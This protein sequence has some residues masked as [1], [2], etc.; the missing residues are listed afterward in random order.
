VVP[1]LLRQVQRRWSCAIVRKDDRY[2]KILETAA[3]DPSKATS[4]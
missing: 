4:R 1:S 3:G 2:G